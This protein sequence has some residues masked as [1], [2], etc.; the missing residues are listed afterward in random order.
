[1]PTTYRELDEPAPVL[2]DGGREIPGWLLAR[3]RDRDGLRAYVEWSTGVGLNHLGWW[4]A[5]DV[6]AA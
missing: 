5:R 3:R 1:M 4:D 2:L 6:R